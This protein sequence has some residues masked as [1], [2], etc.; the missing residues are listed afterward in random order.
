MKVGA[1]PTLILVLAAGALSCTAQS[2]EQAPYTQA[3]SAPRGEAGGAAALAPVT[4]EGQPLAANIQRVVEALDS[5]GAPL[6]AD[7]RTDLTKAG[8]ARDATRLQELLDARVLLVVHINPEARVKVAR[9]PA[10]AALQQAGYAPV[11]VKIVNESRGT[12]RLRIASPHSGP[13]YAGMSRLSAERMQQQHMR[14]NE[15]TDRRTDRFLDLEMFTASPMTASL[16]GL[17][18]EYAVALIYSSESGRR[19]ATVTF[20]V[21][22]G[23]QDLGFRAELPVLFDVK[24]AVRVKLHVLDHDGA[25][26]TA[27]FQFVDQQGHVVPPQAKR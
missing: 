22:Q 11:L 27:R 23:T 18:A 26:T 9:G 20:D 21:G 7:L 15:N 24:P 6:P 3:A 16:S 10:Q 5:L 14:D 19:E 12:Q 1:C 4:V 2:R 8:R 17:E 25:P 13:V